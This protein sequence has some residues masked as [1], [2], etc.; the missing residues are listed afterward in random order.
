MTVE[1]DPLTRRGAIFRLRTTWPVVV[2]GM[3]IAANELKSHFGVA[4]GQQN[5]IGPTVL[6][7][8]GIVFAYRKLWL[9][10]WFWGMVLATYCL[11]LLAVW[12]FLGRCFPDIQLTWRTALIAIAVEA[13]CF[14]RLVHYF[15]ARR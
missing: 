10:G 13:I 11:H 1:K 4:K 5:L 3:A 8:G 7:L 6:F 12:F 2:V 15:E 14:D 9:V